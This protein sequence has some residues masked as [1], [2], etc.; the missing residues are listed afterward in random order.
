MTETQSTESR[1]QRVEQRYIPDVT[2]PRQARDFVD[3]FLAAVGAA[4]LEERADLLT[5]ELVA[6]A[7]RHAPSQ[8]VVRVAFDRSALRV[9]VSDDP[10]IIADPEA[11]KAERELSRRHAEVLAS[12]WGSSFSRDI[13]TTWFELRAA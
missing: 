7:V 12:R 8:V 2:T 6:D 3:E 11:G 4:D 9:E 5:S 13:T 1:I 10:G